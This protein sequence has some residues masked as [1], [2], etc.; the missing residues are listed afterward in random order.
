MP[1]SQFTSAKIQSDGTVEVAGPFSVG[2]GEPA[3]PALVAFYLEQGP[4]GA[5][6][7]ADGEGRWLPGKPNWTG[8][9][10]SEGLTPGPARGTAVAVLQHDDNPGFVTFTWNSSVDVT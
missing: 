4:A 5:E 9:C 7:K 8:T 10:S 1:K 3:K 6:T 2:Q